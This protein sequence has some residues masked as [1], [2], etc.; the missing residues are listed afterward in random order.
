[1]MASDINNDEQAQ[2][3]VEAGRTIDIV[4]DYRGH[5]EG[6]TH[7]AKCPHH[8]LVSAGKDKTFTP[9]CVVV[10]YRA[11]EQL[12]SGSA[13]VLLDPT[14]GESKGLAE[15]LGI[16]KYRD[17]CT[18]HGALYMETTHK[19]LVLSTGERN[20]YHDS[21]F[22]ATVWDADK[23]EPSTLVYGS[24]RGW[25]YPNHA[26]PDATPE[27][28]EAYDAWLAARAE[29][30]RIADA[31]ARE[32]AA[33]ENA[34]APVKGQPA[35]VVKGRKVPVGTEGTVVWL[36]EGNYGMRCGIKDATGEV[37][38][39]AASNVA[40][41]GHDK[42]EDESWV[43]WN[44]RTVLEAHEERQAAEEAAPTVGALVTV[45]SGPDKGTSGKVFWARGGRLGIAREGAARTRRGYANEDVV[46]TAGT[47]VIL[48]G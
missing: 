34:L 44:R 11:A 42:P 17:A 29:E 20:G 45:H 18:R 2:E 7:G 22:T 10:E 41:T 23:G 35:V 28:R 39:T 25:T 1:M 47:N 8:R 24:T 33:K 14:T 36:G 5:E 6:I 21:D 16:D 15:D 26:T 48:R 46:W 19:G 13:C 40:R 12:G 30:A 27:V 9:E 32:E 31:K 3:A 38:W 37:H 4:R 43:E